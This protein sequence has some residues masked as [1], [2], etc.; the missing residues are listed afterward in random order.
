[1]L[2]TAPLMGV[3][4]AIQGKLTVT[5]TKRA[6]DSSAHAVAVAEEVRAQSLPLPQ[7]RSDLVR[8]PL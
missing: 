4:I 5:F 7:F 3:A 6:S 1:M 8:A 2:G